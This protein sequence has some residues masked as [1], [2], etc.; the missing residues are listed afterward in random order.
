MIQVSSFYIIP[1]YEETKLGL[2]FPKLVQ[3]KIINASS[4]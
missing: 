4:V 1:L 2:S 3:L